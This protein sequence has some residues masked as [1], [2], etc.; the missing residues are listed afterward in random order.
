M[1]ED[2]YMH[3]FFFLK[4]GIFLQIDFNQR[5]SISYILLSSSHAAAINARNRVH[6]AHVLVINDKI[7][8]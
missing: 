7:G 6:V 1:H 4:N 2:Q 3:A 8:E 5:I